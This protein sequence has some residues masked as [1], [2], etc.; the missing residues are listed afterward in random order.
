MNV[1]KTNKAKKIL[2]R[3]VTVFTSVF[4]DGFE[5]GV[6]KLR[7]SLADVVLVLALEKTLEDFFGLSD[8]LNKSLS[9]FIAF[10]SLLFDLLFKEIDALHCNFQSG[11]NFT[12]SL[13][14]LEKFWR[15]SFL[16]EFVLVDFVGL[17]LAGTIRVDAFVAVL[18]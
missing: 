7:S 14:K 15:K 11:N 5:R 17:L 13:L 12:E 10:F 16:L 18:S 6:C 1:R 3:K 9:V 8:D 4:S 2:L